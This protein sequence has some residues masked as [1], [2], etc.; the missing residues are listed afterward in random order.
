[1]SHQHRPPQAATQEEANRLL[2]VRNSGFL[3]FQ[4]TLKTVSLVLTYMGF[5]PC[6]YSRTASRPCKHCLACIQACSQMYAVHLMALADKG[7]QP[8]TGM[9]ATVC[10]QED[11]SG[12]GQSPRR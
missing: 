3:Q 10:M 4:Q 11:A 8:K 9:H 12:E 2:R 5:Q 1:M 6:S 7:K